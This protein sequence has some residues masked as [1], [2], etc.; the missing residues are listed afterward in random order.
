MILLLLL[1]M[2][3]WLRGKVARLILLLPLL[4][5][6]SRLMMMARLMLRLMTAVLPGAA[7]CGSRPGRCDDHRPR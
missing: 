1:L 4:L 6:L 2:A 5:L 3:P 7:R